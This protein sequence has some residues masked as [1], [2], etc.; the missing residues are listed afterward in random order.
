MLG[1]LPEFIDP[2]DWAKAG[3]ELSGRLPLAS[4]GRLCANL[5]TD[6]GWVEVALRFALI[7]TGRPVLTGSASC[8]VMVR[9]QR[10]V[11]PLPVHLN[12]PIQLGIVPS[13]A[14]AAR[15]QADYEPLLCRS[16]EN[17]AVADL[18]EDELLLVLPDYP[19]H[20]AGACQAVTVP[21]ESQ[22]QLQPF[23]VLRNLKKK[24]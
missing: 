18:V 6:Q 11:E 8:D 3:R 17:L 14:A 23:A 15:L 19:H 1:R 16:G 13:D 7:D 22:E 21:A 10:C 4:L 12:A 9:C 5:A 2:Y 20:A 24:G